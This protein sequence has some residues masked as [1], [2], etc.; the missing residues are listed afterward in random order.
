MFF[1]GTTTIPLSDV[2]HQNHQSVAMSQNRT[3]PTL[4]QYPS[5]SQLYLYRFLF[6]NHSQY[7]NSSCETALKTWLKAKTQQTDENLVFCL[8]I[9]RKFFLK[10]WSLAGLTAK[11][12]LRN[13]A[14]MLAGTPS[15]NLSP[16]FRSL[17][18]R[19]SLSR[20]I[21]LS[22]G[23]CFFVF[24]RRQSHAERRSLLT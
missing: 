17:F 8:L 6:R 18:M 23:E 11:G 3:P 7:K 12:I 14:D 10:L 5:K 19:H 9:S 21:N 24:A 22:T 13:K 15:I 20:K 4:F 16:D 2:M 1:T